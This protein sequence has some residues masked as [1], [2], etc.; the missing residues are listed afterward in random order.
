MA[1]LEYG[2]RD[3]MFNMLKARGEDGSLLNMAQNL[4]EKNDLMADLPSLP[5]NGGRTHSTVQG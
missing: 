4:I 3:N 5:A 2:N 1:E